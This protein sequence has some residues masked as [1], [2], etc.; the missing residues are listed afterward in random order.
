MYE[1]SMADWPLHVLNSQHGE[2]GFLGDRMAAFRV[3]SGGRWSSMDPVDRLTAEIRF[4]GEM[5]RHL[6]GKN[7]RVA[8]QRWLH[9]MMNLSEL[10]GYRN[11]R[12]F[13]KVMHK[14]YLRG[15]FLWKYL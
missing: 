14:L 11:R 2:I 1:L 15:G 9:Q 10:R 12:R 13:W 3:H 6:R 5:A 8:R 7:A 4:L